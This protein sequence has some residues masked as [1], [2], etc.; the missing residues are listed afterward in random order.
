METNSQD[1]YREGL[2]MQLMEACARVTYTYT[3][4]LKQVDRISKTNRTMK[5]IQIALSAM[6]TG[7]FISSIIINETALTYVSAVLSAILLGIT[8]YYKDFDLNLEITKHT[9]CAN[10]LWIIRE[11]YTS[12]LTDFCIKSDDEI[13]KKRDDL[14]NRTAEIYATA[15]K[16]S[17]KSYRDAQKALKCEEEQ[18][19]TIEE[20]YQLMPQHIRDSLNIKR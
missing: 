4:H 20:L 16:T 10:A 5:Y 9:S 14:L 12:L 8:L 6:T 17:P 19:F 1:K 11:E 18:F 7:G 2:K 13:C 15:P 3:T